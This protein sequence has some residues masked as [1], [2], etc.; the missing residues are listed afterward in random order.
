MNFLDYL[1]DLI[2]PDDPAMEKPGV[3]AA[4][5]RPDGSYLASL[6]VIIRGTVMQL[7]PELENNNNFRTAAQKMYDAKK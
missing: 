6:P 7:H 3:S 4:P 1:D 5:D 2:P